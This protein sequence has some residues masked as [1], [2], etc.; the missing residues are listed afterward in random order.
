MALR[1][2][3]RTT[4]QAILLSY[5]QGQNA[6]EVA[7]NLKV[8]YTIVIN[9]LHEAGIPIRLHNRVPPAKLDLTLETGFR[10]LEIVDGLMLGDGS[11][12]AFG[13][14]RLGQCE[15]RKDW[16]HTVSHMLGDIGVPSKIF[17]T[18][19]R[20]KMLIE[21]HLANSTG[22]LVLYTPTFQ[23][24]KFQRDRWYPGGTKRIPKD[25]VITPLS[26]ALWFFGD[27]SGSEGGH[28]SF[29]THGFPETDLKWIS[30]QLKVLWGIRVGVV[31]RGTLE[32]TRRN[33]A[34]ILKNLMEPYMIPCFRYKVRWVRA[35]VP[36]GF[37]LRKL[38]ESQVREIRK[39]LKEGVTKTSMA[40]KFGV[41]TQ[42]IRG[43]AKG[44][45]YLNVGLESPP[46]G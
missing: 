19:P 34:L 18:Y 1:T 20:N 21:E 7:R 12:D 16:I 41:C 44:R 42:T 30:D 22:G 17:K 45:V 23:D 10:F 11:I 38:T 35:A 4:D 6:M 25:L 33:D 27:G 46:R 31:K 15:R 40:K 2:T 26:V 5:A 9:R 28:M 13:V 8:P 32:V 36:R 3:D 43:I 39:G 24:T 29:S 37:A 14:L